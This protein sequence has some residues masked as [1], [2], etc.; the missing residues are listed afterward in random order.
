MTS[1]LTTPE[2]ALTNI[3]MRYEYA[4]LSA[5]SGV[6]VPGDDAR[7]RADHAGLRALADQRR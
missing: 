1:A 5:E 7:Q 6:D 3:T 4:L 2:H